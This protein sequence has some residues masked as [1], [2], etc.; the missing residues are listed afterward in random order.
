MEFAKLLRTP[1][2]TEHFR[3]LL[4]IFREICKFLEECFLWLA[5]SEITGN[6]SWKIFYE[7]VLVCSP[8]VLL[9]NVLFYLRK[10][11][12]Y[13]GIFVLFTNSSIFLTFRLKCLSLTPSITKRNH[14]WKYHL[15]FFL[16]NF[17]IILFCFGGAPQKE[18]LC[19]GSRTLFILKSPFEK[20]NFRTWFLWSVTFHSLLVT[21]WN[22]LAALLLVVKSLVTRCKVYLL[23]FAE[24]ASCKKSLVTRCEKNPALLDAKFTCYSLQKLLIAKNYSLLVAKL[25]VTGCI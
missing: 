19:R 17:I 1:I 11:S 8:N 4:L 5:T 13:D 16:C 3:W 15:I 14:V 21:R 25:L 2:F 12:S 6:I 7:N 10:R 18:P 23:L 24:V 9:I 22:L 20:N